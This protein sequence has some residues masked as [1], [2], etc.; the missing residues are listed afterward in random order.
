MLE[1]I[2]LVNISFTSH[3]CHFVAT[4]RTLK[5]CSHS[6]LH[7]FSEVLLSI[8]TM[9]YITCL[10]LIRI[11]F[12]LTKRI[13]GLRWGWKAEEKKSLRKAAREGIRVL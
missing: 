11:L 2:M 9:L 13:H 6:H 8:V 7:V 3:N 1:I 12:L 10:Q 5:L 4:V